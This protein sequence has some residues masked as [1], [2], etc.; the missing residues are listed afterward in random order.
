MPEGI[1]E[2][3]IVSD[4]QKSLEEYNSPINHA[5][6][7]ARYAQN[8]RLAQERR[9][10]RL[11]IARQQIQ[12]LSNK[13]SKPSIAVAKDLDHPPKIYDRK[14][15]FKELA[16]RFSSWLPKKEINPKPEANKDKIPVKNLIITCFLYFNAINFCQDMKHSAD[17][18]PLDS[19]KVATIEYTQSQSISA[20]IRA[21]GHVDQFGNK[22]N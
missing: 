14:N 20:A 21:V 17:L 7:L 13:S 2:R 22:K 18:N 9:E 1:A 10:Q 15:I 6:R 11:K 16:N 3:L 8:D 12:E 19:Y 4:N 5:A